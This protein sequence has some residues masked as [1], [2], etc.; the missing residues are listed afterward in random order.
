MKDFKILFVQRG[1]CF[2]GDSQ[3]LLCEEK[4]A[5]LSFLLH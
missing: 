4:G 1:P 5:R 2:C 3:D